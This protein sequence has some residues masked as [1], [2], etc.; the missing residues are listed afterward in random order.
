VVVADLFPTREADPLSWGPHPRRPLGK[1]DDL[2]GA[3]VFRASPAA[4]YLL[5]SVIAVDGGWLAR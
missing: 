4:E 3:I 5:G 1:P 2:K